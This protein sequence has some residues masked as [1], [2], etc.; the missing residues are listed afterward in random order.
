MLFCK[1]NRLLGKTVDFGRISGDFPCDWLVAG[2]FFV[3][4]VEK[5]VDNVDNLAEK[6]W[7]K[8]HNFKIM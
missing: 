2:D 6:K 3:F 1:P 7:G 8:F 5:P 4:S